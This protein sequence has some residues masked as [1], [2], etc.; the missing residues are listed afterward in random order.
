VDIRPLGIAWF[1]AFLVGLGMLFLPFS[2]WS[3]PALTFTPD[4]HVQGQVLGTHIS[5]IQDRDLT[6]RSESVL[7][8]L[9]DKAFQL[10]TKD[11][12]GFHAPDGQVWLRFTL[13]NS[14]N[15][16]LS[17]LLESRYPLLDR[18]TL[19]QLNKEGRWISNS[20]GDTIPFATRPYE[21]RFPT[22]QIR[23]AP[24]ENIYYLSMQNH[25]AFIASLFLWDE[26][27][28]A[29]YIT[30]DTQTLSMFYAVMLAML[31]Y[32]VLLALSLRYRV[33]FYY[34]IYL[35]CFIILQFCIQG[36]FFQW[37]PFALGEWAMNQ[38]WFLLIALTHMFSGLFAIDFLKMRKHMPLAYL[39]VRGL[40][41]TC[42]LVFVLIFVLPYTYIGRILTVLT[43]IASCTLIVSGA[44][45]AWRGF[46]PAIYYT[47]SWTVLLVGSSV[48]ALMYNG[49]LPLHYLV[50]WGHLI[51]GTMEVI[52]MS[53]ALGS[54]ISFMQAHALA[55][56]KRLHRVKA[57]FIANTSHELRTPL[58]GI[59]GMAEHLAQQGQWDQAALETLLDNTRRLARVV[60]D[61]T[62]FQ[63]LEDSKLQLTTESFPLSDLVREAL[64][65]IDPQ[66]RQA[67]IRFELDLGPTDIRVQAARREGVRAVGAVLANALRFTTKGQV[68]V[69]QRRVGHR[70][71]LHIEDTGP[72]MSPEQIQRLGTV[73]EQ[74]DG[75]A[76]RAKGGTGI[77]LALAYRLMR[78]QGGQLTIHSQP[79]QGTQ[80]ILTFIATSAQNEADI[81]PLRL[82]PTLA[83]DHPT[84]AE[85][86]TASGDDGLPRTGATGVTKSAECVKRGAPPARRLFP[87]VLQETT[88]HHLSSRTRILVVDDEDINR[89]VI[90]RHLGEDFDL[91]EA[92]SGAA[93]LELYEGN[94]HFDAVLLDVMMPNMDGYEV[95]RR[96]RERAN[97]QQ[98]PILM[99]T[100]KNQP[101]DIV[102]GFAAGANDYI[103]K[104]FSK[105]ELEARLSSHLQMA[106]TSRAM[107]RFI[108]ADMIRLLGC[109]HIAELDLGMATQH[110]FT[111][112][113]AD[114]PGFTKVMESLPPLH[115]FQWLNRCFEHMGPEIRRAGGFI[116]KYLGD[117]VL[118]L[119][120]ASPDLA[121]TAAVAMH[122]STVQLADISL[123]IGIHYG[124]TMVGTLGEKE[125]FDATV[126]SDAV[127][128]A[129]RIEGCCAILGASIVVSANCKQALEAPERWQWRSLGAMRLKGRQASIELYELLDVDSRAAEKIAELDPFDKAL[130]AFRSGDYET[131]LQ[132]WDD[133]GKK[134]PW[135]SVV[136]FFRGHCREVLSSGS[137]REGV[138]ELKTKD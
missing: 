39:I 87:V 94:M 72:G 112:V 19:Y 119:F 82:Q 111:I 102:E 98:L 88:P 116:D 130:S 12:P 124:Q 29:P 15:T 5:F 69:S 135:D 113:F 126:L 120:P 122:Q 31:A 138:L 106:R 51:G 60:D 105:A 25:G 91:V 79:S 43:V 80:V 89:R 78:A 24:G 95:A 13:T 18:M 2:A 93:A 90:H 131:A 67:A 62:R 64:A 77:G 28:F 6:Y 71:E 36:S 103:P 65:T 49:L 101:Q 8:G 44:S 84:P 63:A 74:G 57:E 38:G 108:P 81:I 33:S 20:M 54:R 75:T 76:S 115:A 97:A 17:L 133:L 117:G 104:P 61:I 132:L 52:L 107:Q 16:E 22:F 45:A 96:L 3:K 4:Q 47:I 109:K 92:S 42:G 129:A 1:E 48:L 11:F 34:N 53:L 86:S 127:N 123:R 46:R 55:E 40:V 30:K 85:W 50:Q 59:L 10:S 70:V 21:F 134:A 99:I 23:L 41:F 73:F 83:P 110:T 136:Q 32:N 100:A 27:S 7:S 26:Y 137:L 121:L 128:V 35:V 114:I 66:D 56:Q 37:A 125:R 9:Y 58:Q 68:R 118:A 14:S